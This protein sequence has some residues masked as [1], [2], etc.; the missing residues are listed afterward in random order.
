MAELREPKTKKAEQT[1]AM[2]LREAFKL[3]LMKGY[4]NATMVE[5]MKAT[6]L[7]RGAI[8][9]YA[10]DKFSLF[11]EVADKF[12]LESQSFHTKI[13]Y[14]SCT[15]FYVFIQEYVKLIRTVTDDLMSIPGNTSEAYIGLIF[16]TSRYYPGFDRKISLSFEQEHLMWERALRDAIKRGEIRSDIDI[17]QVSRQFWHTYL[18]YSLEVCFRHNVDADELY[19]LYMIIYE[20][21]KL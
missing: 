1:K 21:I 20:T 3:F 6:G 4:E 16:Q 7:S 8:F 19:T 13:D 10:E 18:G 17:K 15:S 11:K 5:L 2:I 12:L 14:D 9:Y